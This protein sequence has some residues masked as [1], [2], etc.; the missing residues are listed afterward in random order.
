MVTGNSY[1]LFVVSS[2]GIS[3][4]KLVSSRRVYVPA[5]TPVTS[6]N[7]QGRPEL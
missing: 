4:R 3:L 7:W 2:S 6:T 5:G 1:V